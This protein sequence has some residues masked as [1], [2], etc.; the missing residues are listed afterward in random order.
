[1]LLFTCIKAFSSPVVSLPRSSTSSVASHPFH[2]SPVFSDTTQNHSYKAHGLPDDSLDTNPFDF[3]LSE[4][5][6]NNPFNPRVI[7]FNVR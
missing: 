4:R 7:R 3:P 2:E 6:R 5:I 1:M